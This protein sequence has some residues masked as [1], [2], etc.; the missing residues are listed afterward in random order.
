MKLSPNL[1]L[2]VKSTKKQAHLSNL[3]L[4]IMKLE[5]LLSFVREPAV[6]VPPKDEKEDN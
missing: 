5:K 6:L 1:R 2:K 3:E 4:E